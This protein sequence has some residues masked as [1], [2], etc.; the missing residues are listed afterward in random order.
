MNS[1][2]H[3]I[4]ILREL[5]FER[6]VTEEQVHSDIF[7][8]RNLCKITFSRSIGHNRK[9]LY[10]T[11]NVLS[12]RS[13]QPHR[14]VKF[15]PQKFSPITRSTRQHGKTIT[16]YNTIQTTKRAR[17]TRTKIRM[18]PHSRRIRTS[19]TTSLRRKINL[20]PYRKLNNRSLK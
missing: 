4:I 16:R 1:T 7:L 13:R 14:L 5:I 20:T 17:T 11:S 2:F 8:F 10:R 6:R 12:M 15:K 19:S 18:H 3:I 9:Y